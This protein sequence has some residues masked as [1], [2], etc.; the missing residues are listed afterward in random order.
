MI[1]FLAQY[2]L[3]LKS[4]GKKLPYTHLNLTTWPIVRK[5]TNPPTGLPVRG[6][7]LRLFLPHPA[8]HYFLGSGGRVLRY[9]TSFRS[10]KPSH[11]AQASWDKIGFSAS[12][13]GNLPVSR[14]HPRSI[15][16]LPQSQENTPDEGFFSCG[17]GHWTMLEPQYSDRSRIF[18]Y[19]I[20]EP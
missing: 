11:F 7:F 5:N 1:A 18:T 17:S 2:Y 13:T 3:R 19:P 15:P 10:L 8:I 12:A 14:P 6:F 4:T 9:L 16:T 20:S